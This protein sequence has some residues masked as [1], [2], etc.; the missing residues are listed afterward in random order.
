VVEKV[1]ENTSGQGKLATIPEEIRGWNWGAFLLN[2]IWGIGNNVWIALLTLIPY[3]NIIM[4]F[5]LGVK[6]NEWAWRNRKWDSIEHFKRVQRNWARVGKYIIVVSLI[7]ILLIW[8]LAVVVIPN[9]G[10]FIG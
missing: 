2:W 4:P 8:I 10:R 7:L 9:L 1:I 3:V 5:V 6:G